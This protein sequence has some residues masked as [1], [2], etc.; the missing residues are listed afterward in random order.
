MARALDTITR[1]ILGHMHVGWAIGKRG[2]VLDAVLSGAAILLQ[3]LEADAEAM[4]DEIDPR[5]ARKLLSDFERVLGPDPCGRDLTQPSIA[6]RQALA[7]QRWTAFGGQDIPYF[8]RIAAALGADVEIREYWP[9]KAG[10]LVAGEALIGDGEQFLFSVHLE[11]GETTYFRAGESMA[12]DR[13]G[14]FDL[15]PVECELRRIRPFHTTIVFSYHQ[16]LMLGD[17]MLVLGDEV[18]VLSEGA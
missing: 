9:S 10:A 18:L 13:L 7:Y 2:G 15:S 4:A 3:D 16:T 5:N 11:T 1:S 12:T 14:T 6:E 8:M 17:Q